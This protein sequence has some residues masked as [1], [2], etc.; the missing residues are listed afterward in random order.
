VRFDTYRQHVFHWCY[1]LNNFLILV[2]KEEV[3]FD[4][5]LGNHNNEDDRKPDAKPNLLIRRPS[6]RSK[7]LSPLQ[8]HQQLLPTKSARLKTKRRIPSRTHC[9]SPK[10]RRPRIVVIKIICANVLQSCYK[11]MSKS[12]NCQPEIIVTGNS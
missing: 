8:R 5:S 6:S 11:M 9:T 10:R 2:T 4:R 1:P 3:I 12:K 7:Q